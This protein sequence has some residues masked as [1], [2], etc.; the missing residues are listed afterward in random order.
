V[1]KDE[2]VA[3]PMLGVVKVIDAAILE[4]V[5]ADEAILASV[6]A[7]DAMSSVL[8]APA[9]KFAPADNNSQNVFIAVLFSLFS[10]AE[11][12]SPVVNVWGMVNCAISYCS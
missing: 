7:D 2:P 12:V 5:T 8:I 9:S 3:T 6:I 11:I 1:V 4:V 10:I